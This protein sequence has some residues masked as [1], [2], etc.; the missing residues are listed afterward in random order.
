M[1][2]ETKQ[3][4]D[5]E[6]WHNHANWSGW[7]PFCIYFSKR[8]SRLFVP[9]C[10]NGW[11]S[12]HVPNF[13]HRFAGLYVIVTGLMAGIILFA[14]LRM[15]ASAER[16]APHPSHPVTEQDTTRPATD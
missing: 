5:D 4:I 12:P 9:Q 2:D 8:D 6:E 13:G 11:L 10:W 16:N 3:K 1:S 7:G 14:G 15:R